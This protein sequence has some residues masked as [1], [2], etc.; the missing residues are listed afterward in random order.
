MDKMY[1]TAVLSAVFLVVSSPFA[2]NLTNG[3]G[4]KTTKNGGSP[5]TMGL[6]LH[7][8]IF[9]LIVYLLMMLKKRNM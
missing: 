1:S 7:T 9:A 8:I 4:L 3:L 5:T 2:Y 6:I